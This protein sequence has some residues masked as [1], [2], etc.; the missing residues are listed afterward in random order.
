MTQKVS[1][2]TS[3]AWSTLAD[4]SQ[5]YVRVGGVW[6]LAGNAYIHASGAWYQAGYQP[7][8]S[9]PL[10]VRITSAASNH[11]SMT[12]A[13]DKPTI[14]INVTSYSVQVQ[15][16]TSAGAPSGSPSIFSVPSST[17]SFTFSPVTI[18]TKYQIS[19]QAETLLAS[20]GYSPVV[21]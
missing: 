2:H 3:G 11:T 8:V 9:V 6:K 17:T 15:A 13:W 19:V 10:N 16:C 7:P 21:K 18:N 5:I 4:S 14:G 20:S 1:I 12:V